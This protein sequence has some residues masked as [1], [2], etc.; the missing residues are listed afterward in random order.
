MEQIIQ[1]RKMLFG[2]LVPEACVNGQWLSESASFRLVTTR[3]EEHGGTILQLEFTNLS[4][5]TVRL[6]DLRFIQRGTHGDFLSTP[7]PR[8][9]LYRE[10]WTMAS[11]AA[12]VRYGEKDFEV[13]PGYK[14]FAVSMPSE[15]SSEKPN[16]FSG[17]HVA[18]LNDRESGFSML[19]GF[20]TSANQMTRVVVE[21]GG[22]GVKEYAIYADTDGIEVDHGET[23]RS[24]ELLILSGT[25]AYALLEQFATV[26][27]E[28]MH[29]RTWDHLPN[30]WCSWYYYFSNVTEADILENAAYLN[31][32]RDEYP[33]EYL[34]LAQTRHLA[35]TVPGGETV[36]SL[37]RASRLDGPRPERRDRLPDEM[38]HR[39]GRHSGWNASRGAA[40]PDRSFPP[41][42][43]NGMGL[44]EARLSRF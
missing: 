23:V 9:R 11:A 27:G 21:L 3:K 8:L 34:Q 41:S 42:A 28:K 24:E 7:G 5:K 19:T 20:V 43:R 31:K 22:E 26:W 40:F 37:R 17:E 14:P 32:H 38:A 2:A 25:D 10:G 6:D 44:Y 15:Y 1:N 35:C 18:V 12:S 33:L 29:A 13:D 4:G 39:R 36:P 30:G 16:R